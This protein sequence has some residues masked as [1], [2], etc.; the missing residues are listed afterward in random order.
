MQLRSGSS[1]QV[2]KVFSQH[3]EDV[4]FPW[5]AAELRSQTEETIGTMVNP[6]HY[7]HCY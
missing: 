5:G 7:Y 4:A 6:V 3:A 2:K 1:G